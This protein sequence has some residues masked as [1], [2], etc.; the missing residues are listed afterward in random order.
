[1]KLPLRTVSANLCVSLILLGHICAGQTVPPPTPAAPPTAVVDHPMVAAPEVPPKASDKASDKASEKASEKEAPPAPAPSSAPV[2]ATPAK[3]SPATSASGKRYIIGP[4]D[5]LEIRVWND[6]RLSGFFPV[7]PDGVIT[8]PLIGD[9]KAD[10]LTKEQLAESIRE[11]LAETVFAKTPELNE[12]T[13]TVI[14]NNSKK[15]YVYGGV[16][17]PGEFPLNGDMTVMDVLAL[18]LPFKDFAKPKGIYILRGNNNKKIPFN[19][20]E[21]IKGRKMDQNIQLMSGDRIIVPE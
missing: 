4:L 1:M 10:G 11:K 18:C 9:V 16:S 17:R 6:Q 13:A 8:M 3:T 7:S 12:V 14:R 5:E 20:P 15:V 21:F 2:A 19:S